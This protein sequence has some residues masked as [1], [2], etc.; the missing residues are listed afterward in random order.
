MKL[1]QLLNEIF[2]PVE[3]AKKVLHKY[4][5]AYIALNSPLED[6]RNFFEKYNKNFYILT[7]FHL[8]INEEA[9][10]IATP[11]NY[12]KVRYILKPYKDIR[13]VAVED[14]RDLIDLRNDALGEHK[15][16]GLNK[17]KGTILDETETTF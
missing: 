12:D 17:I 10:L 5:I 9:L 14:Y 4:R 13:I 15:I 7:D 1:L 2:L 3:K 11:F 6:I 8:H 16:N